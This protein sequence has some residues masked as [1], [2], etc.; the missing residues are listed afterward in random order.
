MESP[1]VTVLMACY[2]SNEYKFKEAIRSVLEQ[3]FCNYELVIVD[4]GSD[5]P[6]YNS[7]KEFCDSRIKVYKINHSG[8]GAALN[9]GASV[10]LGKYI[11]RFDD[12][13][14]MCPERL[15][16]QVNYLNEHI[17]CSC[18]GTMHYDKVENK[19]LKHRKYPTE[20]TAIIRSLLSLKWAMAH[21]TVM[22]RKES[23]EKIG[24]YRI[25]G[26]GQ[27]LDLF[28]QLGTVGELANIN[29]YLVYYTMST[30]GLSQINPR[31]SEAYLFAIDDIIKRG[32]FKEFREISETSATKLKNMINKNKPSTSFVRRM[33]VYKV[34][35]LGSK[36]GKR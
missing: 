31:K 12:D 8:L 13:D 27:D 10:A 32:L 15:E 34:K 29:D 5:N 7:T 20:H 9:Y 18:V 36:Y 25:K 2:N 23:F 6:I 24:G 19:Y 4:D 14:I 21:T 35:F 17:N 1:L 30:K 3:T 22:F 26:G 16:K 33:I 28:L 11:A